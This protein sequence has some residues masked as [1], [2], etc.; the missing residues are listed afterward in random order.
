MEMFYRIIVK[1]GF[2]II[3]GFAGTYI[4]WLIKGKKQSF[5]PLISKYGRLAAVLLLMFIALVLILL[6]NI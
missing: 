2:M 6:R 1:A 4:L 3:L 5:G